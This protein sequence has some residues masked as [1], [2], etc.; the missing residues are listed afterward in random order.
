ML[1]FFFQKTSKFFLLKHFFGHLLFYYLQKKKKIALSSDSRSTIYIIIWIYLYKSGW[2]EKE[3]Y[4]YNVYMEYKPTHKSCIAVTTLLIRRLG[5]D[6]LSPLRSLF[7]PPP[8]FPPSLPAAADHRSD[9]L[10]LRINT[11]RILTY[12]Q[13][14]FSTY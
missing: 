14:T 9:Q 11:R 13:Y 3:I 6:T 10:C 1:I 4:I 2:E 7:L 12:I 5:S 8:L